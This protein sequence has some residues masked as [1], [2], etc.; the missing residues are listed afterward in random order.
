MK[1]N[2]KTLQN[3]RALSLSKCRYLIF[4]IS[5]LLIQCTSEPETSN[6]KLQIP[7]SKSQLMPASCKL[8][9]VLTPGQ[10][11]ILLPK[12]ITTDTCPKPRTFQIPK[13]EGGS[14]L[15]TYYD[16]DTAT[17]RF[18][19]P[20]V[21]MLPVVTRSVSPP[22]Q[23]ERGQGGEVDQSA[24]ARGFFTTY[25]TD[26]GLALDAIASG[27]RD[28]TGNLWFG[29]YGGGVSRYDGKSF[30]NFTTAQGLANNNVYSITEDKTGNLWFGTDGGGVSVLLNKY[31][32]HWQK[33]FV[34]SAPLN[35]VTKLTVLNE[36]SKSFEKIFLNITTKDGLSDNVVMGI[37][38]DK[39]GNIF[40]G[41]N[42]GITVL[43]PCS[44]RSHPA[45]GLLNPCSS[46]SHPASGLL[47]LGFESYSIEIYNSSTGY[48]VK[49]VNG[50]SANGAMLIDS[51]GILW[52]GC[53]ASQ[54]ALVRIDYN[55]INR[56]TKPP[57]VIIQNLKV[58][59]EN[60]CWYNLALNSPALQGG[61]KK[62]TRDSSGFS[63]LT[64]EDS[65]SIAPTFRSG[66]KDSSKN[67]QG[68]SPL[69]EDSLA[70][71][72]E[73]VL[74]FGKP[75]A[76]TL[77]DT[78]RYKFGDIKFDGITKFYPLPVNLKLPYNHNNITIEFAAIEPAR[79]YLVKYQYILEGY[80]DDWS[81]VTNKTSATFGNIFEGTYTFKLKACSPDG[82]WSE[83][84]IYTF[85]VLP[86]WY[87]TWWMYAVYAL[88]L[89]SCFWF[90]V[91]WRERKLKAA[92][93]LLEK[94]VNEQ[95]HEL[96]EKN[97]ELNQQNAEINAQ[98][99]EITTQSDTVME[100]K[101]ELEKLSI[102][103]S[104]TD[105]AVIICAQDGVLEWVNRGFERLYGLTLEQFTAQY[106][107][108]I[109]QTSSNPDFKE[110]VNEA[111]ENNRSITYNSQFTKKT[112]ET[113]WLQ[114]T[115]TPIF[116]EANSPVSDEIFIAPTF[117]S[118]LETNH[119]KASHDIKPIGEKQLH[120][121]QRTSSHSFRHLKK[122]I[123]I[124]SDITKVK[125]A[126]DEIRKQ[127][128]QIEII[129]K[130]VT[131][132]INYAKRIQ[133]A[134]LPDLETLSKFS[135][136]IF[137]LFRP[138][139][140]VSGDFYWFAKVENQLVV[141]VA[142]C[143]G[144]GV[145]GAFMSMLGISFLREIVQKEYMTEPSRILHKLRKEIVNALKQKDI[146]SHQK[147]GMDISICSINTDTLEMQWAGA[148]N[149]CWLIQN[150]E[151]TEL[152]PD[153]MPIGIYDRMDKFTA[154]EIKLNKGDIIYLAG[155]GYQDQFGG[156]DNKKFMSKRLKELL[157]QTCPGMS[158]Q[159]K[160]MEEQKE[161]L[162]KTIEDWIYGY[163]TKYEQTDDITVMGI[164]I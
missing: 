134:I 67:K 96:S 12:T 69:N 135:F 71:L 54:I 35:Q 79:P 9:P 111:V 115:L 21:N 91:K 103:A 64:K 161:I 147:D 113:V 30:T 126:E 136:E 53:G 153:K 44:S 28:K 145:P 89:V 110:V 139:D 68:F 57:A 15:Y 106:G 37:R 127:K 76:Q 130:E 6:P 146:E 74:T 78:M 33:Y 164:R 41:T 8:P 7:N 50:G 73:E 42:F 121:T 48:P 31:I 138:K 159:V 160:T 90:L 95:T 119:K 4:I 93:L 101:Q 157:V 55:A 143:T 66:I 39:E 129:H 83:P 109:Y 36:K 62:A 162:D 112:G 75:L 52:V 149:P 142:D 108:T 14:Y 32:Q 58:N 102:V 40:I 19:P 77:R 65:L 45:S 29:T 122:L 85:K 16:G 34:T 120:A 114:T 117:R 3:L 25:T 17:I 86:P 100:Q 92:Q 20:G 80:D 18:K 59:N 70:L 155:D 118:G 49:D 24:A 97:E 124:E 141:T 105:N 61:D 133:T 132:S 128:E 144:H 56:N 87:R 38:E 82:V 5:I 140:V 107:K 150:G 60:I 11:T 27:F 99:D 98:K 88:F 137:V 131:D 154:H 1:N 72:N 2:F 23:L 26:N 148:N 10:D 151:F 84:I 116:E 94:K 104:E 156:P 46:R 22:L 43:S 51:K 123:A 81:P 158:Q 13:K 152:K 47:N 163:E 63:P 125:E